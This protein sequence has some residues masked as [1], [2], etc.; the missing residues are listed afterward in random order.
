MPSLIRVCSLLLA[1]SSFAAALPLAGAATDAAAAYPSKTPTNFY[2]VLTTSSQRPT[3]NNASTLPNVS[4]TSLFDPFH[5]RTFYLRT[6]GP[7]YNSVPQFNLTDGVLNTPAQ[8][9]V[10]GEPI[11]I[12]NSSRVQPGA[13]LGFN[14]QPEVKGTLALK[15]GYLL[16]ADGSSKGWTICNDVLGQDVVSLRFNKQARR[17]VMTELC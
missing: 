9:Y 15:D 7:G 11:S 5:Q 4:A 10:T 12:Y 14:P 13:Q 6:Q 17:L 3:N 1:A 2:L 8:N 16:T